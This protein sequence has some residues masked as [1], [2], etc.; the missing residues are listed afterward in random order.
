MRTLSNATIGIWGLA[1]KA[2]TDD[3][4]DSL[5]LRIIDELGSRGTRMVVFDPAVRIAPLPP[6]S[7]MVT[8]AL[9][10]THADALLV[11]T[12]WPEFALIDPLT[13]ARNLQ[14]RIVV[15]GR[16]VLDSERVA[17][18]GLTYRGVGRSLPRR[19]Q[20][21]AMPANTQIGAFTSAGQP[22]AFTSAAEI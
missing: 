15:D 9:E 8:S 4:R 21:G 3:I 18:A 20:H 5:A 2:G 10:A 17:A 12:E 1:F 7:R 16:N 19:A 14:R 22:G 13:Y 6:G 11:L